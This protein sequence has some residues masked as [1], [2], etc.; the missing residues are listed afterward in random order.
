MGTKMPYIHELPAEICQLNEGDVVLLGSDGR[1]NVVYEI[2]AAHNALMATNRCNLK[3][4]MCPQPSGPD[5][6]GM[7]DHNLAI[8][9]LMDPERTPHLAITGGEPTLIGEEF[10][11]LIEACKK[12]LP[13]TSLIVLSN[14]KRFRDIELVRKLALV[15]HPNLIVAVPLYS[16]IDTIHDDIVAVPGS[17]YETLKGL[18]NL[19]LFKQRVEIRTVIHG[20]N[21]SRL[22]NLA[23]F[24]YHNIP[25]AV[26][27][28]LM[29][30]ETTGLARENIEQLW[31]DPHDYISELKR[32]VKYLHRTNMNVSI[33]N[34]QLCI[35]PK[36]LWPF[37]RQ[38][39]S[40]WKNIYLS[41]CDPCAEKNRCGGFFETG[42]TYYSKH[43]R[44]ISL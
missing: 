21:W 6:K 17:F 9:R 37:C 26:H 29:G 19:A 8:I 23:E 39:I 25:F 27:V 33:Y 14:G 18:Y 30:M 22:P 28:A 44:C 35:L 16:D 13:K 31:M 10:F 40:K 1:V 7:L 43:I 12:Y 38:S 11:E 32:A 3:C 34:H 20:L 15:R 4:V 5:P 42:G 2:S 41:E 36:E 24:I